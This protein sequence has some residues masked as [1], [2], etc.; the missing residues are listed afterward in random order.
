MQLLRDRPKPQVTLRLTAMIDIVFLL[1]I[2]FMTVSQLDREAKEELPLAEASAAEAADPDE[3]RLILNLRRDGS[4]AAGGI[5]LDSA[6]LADLLAAAIAREGKDRLRCVLRV[7]RDAP[8]AAVRG[9]LGHLAT[10]GVWRLSY[11]V[12]PVEA[13]P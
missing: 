10:A 13:A 7:D 1:V 11:S 4:L 8:F 3:G 2:F 9:L 12:I 5:D 6:A